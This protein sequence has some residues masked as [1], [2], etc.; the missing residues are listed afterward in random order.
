[1]FVC[2]ASSASVGLSPGPCYMGHMGHMG[3]RERLCATATVRCQAKASLPE[4]ASVEF[5]CLAATLRLICQELGCRSSLRSVG[6]H[7][8]GGEGGGDA[9]HDGLL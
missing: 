8:V 5:G 7:R 2:L 4:G 1:M 9:L 6:M 3:W